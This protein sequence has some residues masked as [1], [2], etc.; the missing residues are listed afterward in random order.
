MRTS[1]GGVTGLAQMLRLFLILGLLDLAA[2]AHQGSRAQVPSPQPL[3]PALERTALAAAL[4]GLTWRLPLPVPF[5]V[6]LERDGK[7]SEPD[8]SWLVSLGSQRT[9]L[10]HRACPKTYGSMVR[11][12]DSLGRPVDPQPPGGYIDPYKLTVVGPVAVASDRAAVRILASQGTRFWLIYCDVPLPARRFA[13]C[14][15]VE[16]GVS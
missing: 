15:A 13:S 1:L 4:D 5:C 11:T 10:P 16:E 8:S 7:R 12:V 3:P 9:L 14:G 2:C 6:T